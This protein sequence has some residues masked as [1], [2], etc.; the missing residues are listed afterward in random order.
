MNIHGT[1][2]VYET[3]RQFFRMVSPDCTE[4]MGMHASELAG[5]ATKARVCG[6]SCQNSPEA[7]GV[8]CGE[9]S[10]LQARVLFRF[11]VF[12]KETGCAVGVL[13]CF[14][15]SSGDDSAKVLRIELAEAHGSDSHLE[16]TLRLVVLTLIPA[17]ALRGLRIT[18]PHAHDRLPLLKKYGFEPSGGVE[19]APASYQRTERTFFD[20]G[21][22]VAFCGLACCVCSE[23]PVCTGCRKEGCKD[24]EWCQSFNC[25]KKKSLNGCWECPDFPCDNPML[26]KL[27]VRTFAAFI[28]EYGEA[29]L[30]RAL[31]KNEADGVLYHYPDQLIGDYDLPQSEAGIRALLSRGV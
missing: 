18:V 23:N 3:S 19:A 11:A 31:Q 26:N 16:E 21:K 24:K 20:A 5:A 15:R 6:G 9:G 10:G 22:G 8:F 30:I 7:T 4:G 12:S 14:S 28:L 27:R 29:A 25:C 1:G 2:P 13:E 17:Y